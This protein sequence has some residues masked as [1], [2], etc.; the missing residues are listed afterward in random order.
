MPQLRT[1]APVADEFLTSARSVVSEQRIAVSAEA[2][3]DSLAGADDW[4]VWLGL[5]S[6]TY[7]TP[8]PGGVGTTRTVTS[9]RT[10]I[11]EEF[12]AWDRPSRLAFRAASSTLPV[13]AFVEDY[14]IVSETPTTSTL[15]WTVALEGRPGILTPLVLMTMRRMGRS[16]L[17]KLASLLENRSS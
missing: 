12:F 8:N 9:G 17:P 2:V 7:T 5:D 15:T 3:F 10:T 13:R 16:S 14:T 6:V 11:Y 4:R 1:H